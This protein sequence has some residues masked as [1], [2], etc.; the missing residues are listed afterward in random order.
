MGHVKDLQRLRVPSPTQA[1]KFGP[2]PEFPVDVVNALNEALSLL[3]AIPEFLLEAIP[4]VSRAALKQALLTAVQ[5]AWNHRRKE[6]V[7]TQQQLC[8]L[9]GQLKVSERLAEQRADG[10]LEFWQKVAQTS[11]TGT[12]NKVVD[13]NSKELLGQGHWG[14][15]LRCQL[16]E[17]DKAVAV[18]LVGLRGA[19]GA[20]REWQHGAAIG[21]HKN[22]VRYEQALL[23]MDERLELKKFFEQ[24]CNVPG[25]ASRDVW[26]MR[27]ICLVQE[28]AN[29]GS[30]GG[31]LQRT[32]LELAGIGSVVRQVACALAFVHSRKRVHNDVKPDNILLD[33]AGD[34]GVVVKLGDFGLADLAQDVSRD[35]ELFGLTAFCTVT[36]EPFQKADPNA[37]PEYSERASKALK[38]L[39]VMGGSAPFTKLEQVQK[40][41][42]MTIAQICRSQVDM[43][44]VEQ[45]EWL[46]GL[47]LVIH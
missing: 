9:R 13:M 8:A 26:P 38:R 41:L 45:L 34:S 17:P 24:E 4:E 2:V 46:Q 14:F 18:K 16:R 6:L 43:K 3:E 32:S 11:A 20:Q 12:L 1:T 7:E 35:Y 25:K 23:H 22:I 37:A 33:D 19:A 30:L 27:Y 44:E 40:K 29:K 47:D 21:K 42:P 5:T 15:V 39:E 31:L 10:Q 28:F 36:K